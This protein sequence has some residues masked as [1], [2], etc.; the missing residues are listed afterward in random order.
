MS[1]PPNQ[2]SLRPVLLIVMGVSGSGKSSVA[3][4]L[5]QH[6][7][8]H[9]LDADDFHSDEAKAQ[10]A[11]GVPLTD[12]M[13]VP[14]V[15]NICA[16]LKDYAQ[17]NASCTLAFSGLRRSHRDQLRQLPFTIVFVYLCGTKSLIAE[18]MSAREGHFMPA[19]LLD[20]QFASMEDSRGEADV[21]AIDI[22]PELSQVITNC[23]HRIEPFLAT[24]AVESSQPGVD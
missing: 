24:R 5:A 21:V 18:R 15:H 17:K 19:S 10:M 6:Y 4:A 7:Q 3:E 16:H 2:S 23:L 9:Y 20:S 14:W 22:S 11:A 12:E 8:Y 13:R 1:H